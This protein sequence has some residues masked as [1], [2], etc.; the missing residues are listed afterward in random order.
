MRQIFK[1]QAV[2]QGNG[3]APVP[4]RGGANICLYYCPDVY[5][6]T[7]IPVDGQ[8]QFRM[9][10]VEWP[11]HHAEIETWLYPP[12]RRPNRYMVL[13]GPQAPALP[14]RHRFA[15]FPD[16]PRSLVSEDVARHFGLDVVASHPEDYPSPLGR[17]VP[18][19]LGQPIAGRRI[20]RATIEIRCHAGIDPDPLPEEKCFDFLVADNVPANFALLGRDVLNCMLLLY[21]GCPVSGLDDE[22]T[23]WGHQGR[24]YF[25]AEEHPIG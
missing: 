25:G 5:K 15:V 6:N 24:L 3:N 1:H 20:A 18:A 2:L 17:I 16:F 10:V 21:R 12:G 11:D 23:E 22:P 9:E 7:H 19:V 13:S 4:M 8:D 14:A